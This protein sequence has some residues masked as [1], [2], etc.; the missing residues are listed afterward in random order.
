MHLVTEN[1]VHTAG[2][3]RSKGYAGDECDVLYVTTPNRS[4]AMRATTRALR[5]AGVNVNYAFASAITEQNMAALVIGVDDAQ[6]AATAAG[7]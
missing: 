6:R 1:S 5:D 3:L 7:M 4:G 2:L